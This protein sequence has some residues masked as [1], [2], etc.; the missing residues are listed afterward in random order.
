MSND[1]KNNTMELWSQVCKTNPAFTKRVNQRGGFT[2]IC[3]QSQ[4]MEATR[5]WGSYGSSWGLREVNMDFE[6]L[7]K[8]NTCLYAAEFY[9]PGGSFVVNNAIQYLNGDR[10]DDDFAKK[11]ETDTLT[12]ALS[13]LGFNAD[14]FLGFFDD[15]R[16]I[17][18][19]IT[20]V[21][22]AASQNNNEPAIEDPVAT[23]K[24][25]IQQ[26]N[27][28]NEE[29]FQWASQKVDCLIQSFDDLS[30]DQLQS[31]AYHMENSK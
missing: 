12:K 22:E 6:T 14:V 1:S 10:I 30:N 16:Y 4:I 19:R 13:R 26:K 7:R 9:Y 3:A 5:Q 28:T 21:A 11:V 2:A 24:A 29:F 8:S 25:I 18:E 15:Q 17:K 20:E 31:L 27:R 23:I